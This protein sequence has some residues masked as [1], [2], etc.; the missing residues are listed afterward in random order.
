MY[1]K[2]L[3]KGQSKALA[4][5]SKEMTDQS[6]DKQKREQKNNRE[7]KKTKTWVFVK[8]NKIDKSIARLTK[9]RTEPAFLQLKFKTSYVTNIKG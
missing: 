2:E 4:D 6:K 8:M 5:T 7:Y 9:N 3:E 1:L